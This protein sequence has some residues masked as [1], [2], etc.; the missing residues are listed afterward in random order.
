MKVKIYSVSEKAPTP[1]EFVLKLEVEDGIIV[2][3][4]FTKAEVAIPD[5]AEE[6]RICRENGIHPT[7]QWEDEEMVMTDYW[8]PTN[9]F[10]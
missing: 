7:L 8:M 1:G 6:E 3:A 9:V 10:E 2:A 4:S 5:N